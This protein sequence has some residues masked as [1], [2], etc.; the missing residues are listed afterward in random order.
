MTT[1]RV[2]LAAVVQPYRIRSYVKALGWLVLDYLIL[3]SSFLYVFVADAWPTQV[4]A[5]LVV[6]ISIARLFIIGHDACHGALFTRT[7]DQ[8]DH[9]ALGVSPLA[10]TI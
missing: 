10:D 6:W 2:E 1:S 5:S 4:L 7:R 3:A 8:Q 9:R